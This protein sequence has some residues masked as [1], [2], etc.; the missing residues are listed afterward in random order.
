MAVK[1]E[2]ELVEAAKAATNGNKFCIT[3]EHRFG[4][5]DNTKRFKCTLNPKWEQIEDYPQ[6]FK[7]GQ[8]KL[9]E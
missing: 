4:G 3:C 7:C 1:N 5:S 9:K 2:S 8:W 6:N